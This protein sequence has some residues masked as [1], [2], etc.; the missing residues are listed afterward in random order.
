MLDHRDDS[1]Q[2]CARR[3]RP[4]G[5]GNLL[6]EAVLAERT[7][8]VASQADSAPG[9]LGAVHDDE[10]ERLFFSFETAKAASS[11]FPVSRANSDED[12]DRPAASPERFQDVPVGP[13]R[14]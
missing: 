4:L 6:A 12:T 1:V 13:S 8:S 14:A 5:E 11:A 10:V 3:S 2:R 9:R 7:A